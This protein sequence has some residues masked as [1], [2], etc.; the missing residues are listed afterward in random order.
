MKTAREERAL[1]VKRLGLVAPAS[2]PAGL[3]IVVIREDDDGWRIE[4]GVTVRDP[5]TQEVRGRFG[6]INVRIDGDEA[7]RSA[8]RSEPS[9]RRLQSDIFVASSS[10]QSNPPRKKRR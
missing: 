1:L 6:M 10:P 8:S 2:F 4:T 7:E 9:H 3:R 5:M